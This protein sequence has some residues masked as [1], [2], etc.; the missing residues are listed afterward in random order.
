MDFL[1]KGRRKNRADA[2]LKSQTKIFS[3]PKKK[4]KGNL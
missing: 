2:R 4:K 1:S 3:V